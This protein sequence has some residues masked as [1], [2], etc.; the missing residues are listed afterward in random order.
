MMPGASSYTVT[1]KILDNDRPIA[2]RD[3]PYRALFTRLQGNIVKGHGRDFTAN[4]FLSFTTR[5]EALRRTLRWVARKYVTTAY[6]QLIEREHYAH[7]HIPGSLFGN[8][9]LTPGA[10]ERLDLGSRL[11][12]WFDDP[13]R[14]GADDITASFLNGMFAAREE[15]EDPLPPNGQREP[16]EIAYAAKTIDALIVLA[17]DSKPFLLRKVSQLMTRLECDHAAR[18]VAVEIGSALRNSDGEGIEHF[19]YI[20]GRSQPLFLTSDFTGGQ[21]DRDIW[22]PFARLSLALLKDPASDDPLAFGSYY[23][24]RKLEQ[25]VRGFSIAERDLMTAL[26]LKGEDSERAGAM[27]VG[28]FRDGT[29]LALSSAPGFLPAK[30]NNF[31]YDGLNANFEPDP[32]APDDPHGLACPFQAHIRKVN[33]RQNVGVE[34]ISEGSP[35]ELAVQDRSHRIVRRGIT[36][37]E[38]I[39]RPN[40]PQALD[41]LPSEGVGLLFACFQSS[42]RNQFAFMQKQWANNITFRVGADNPNQTGID[43]VIGQRLDGEILPHHWRTQY[44]GRFEH[45]GLI[46]HQRLSRSHP[47]AFP[48]H[49]FVKFKGGEF[50]FAPSLPFL[51]GE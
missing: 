20:D 39:Q 23:V 6:E 44:G 1:S 36:Y 12:E 27:I 40:V 34:D 14:G 42:I 13:D 43:C 3:E 7:F 17:D 32:Y 4:V 9:F 33:P 49:S 28:R 38:R 10:Y 47:T 8:L 5:G 45:E 25:N 31:R 29:P 41:D 26:Q 15:L 24:F 21:E 50:F 11:P 18:I 19:G 2:F 37:G 51:L 48:F 35:A 46:K 30:A 22:D 16:L